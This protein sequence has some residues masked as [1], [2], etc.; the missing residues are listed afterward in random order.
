[1]RLLGS[2]GR[3]GGKKVDH[4]GLDHS[5]IEQSGRGMEFT[6][7][8]ERTT[9]EIEEQPRGWALKAKWRKCFKTSVWSTVE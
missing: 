6:N 1:M 8:T 3:Y 7:E 5:N 2:D 9:L 4:W